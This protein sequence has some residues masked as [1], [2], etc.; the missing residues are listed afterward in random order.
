MLRTALLALIVAGAMPLLAGCSGAGAPADENAGVRG[1]AQDNVDA[2]VTIANWMRSAYVEYLQQVS[3]NTTYPGPNREVTDYVYAD[4][5]TAHKEIDWSTGCSVTT[6]TFP[7]GTSAIHTGTPSSL[8]GT[9]HYSSIYSSG[10]RIVADETIISMSPTVY[11]RQGTT[12]SPTG[13]TVDFYIHRTSSAR[14][15]EDVVEVTLRSGTELK[16]K[17]PL[18]VKYLASNWPVYQ[19]VTTGEFNS[20]NGNTLNFT[21]KGSTP[22]AWDTLSVT[23]SDGTTGSFTL[24]EGMSGSGE[25]RKDGQTIA[26]LTWDK[27]GNGDVAIIDATYDLAPSAA[28]QAFQSANWAYRVSILGPTPGF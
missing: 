24:R 22:E 10:A 27:D 5:T 15:H 9:G 8:P 28:A 14:R 20:P 23:A 6:T 16:M 25:L 11:E 17:I 7:D 2:V 12:T 26:T 1:L 13:S 21:L 3:S 4:G 19:R 18:K